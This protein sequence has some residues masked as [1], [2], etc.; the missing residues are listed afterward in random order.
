MIGDLISAGAIL[1]G[2]HL[3]RQSQEGINQ[4]VLVDKERDRA[5]QR[6]FAQSG[7]QWKVEDAK[8]AGIHPIFALGGSNATYTPSAISLGADTSTGSAVAKVG[9][10]VGRA[11][12]ATRTEPDRIDAYT[13]AVQKLTLEKGA[14]ENQLLGSQIRKLN[15]AGTPPPMSGAVDPYL[16][17]G[18]T[19][20]GV[21]AESFI[22]DDPLKRV[23]GATGQPQ[24]EP[25]AVTDV[26]YARTKDGY[27]P[28]P[29]KDVK[30][31]IEDNIIQ[32]IM[33]AVRNNVLPSFGINSSPPP[34]PPRS[35]HQWNFDPLQ[36][37]Y[38]ERRPFKRNPVLFKE[39]R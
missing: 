3:S 26:G 9:Q 19:Q 30:E 36:Q 2:G 1:L 39:R 6:E 14:L 25:G 18:Q 4:Q 7:I 15:Q 20:S 31:R 10:D 21:K 33:W 29:S 16:I 28:V 17:S 27:A 13:Q 35:G 12:N 32:E 5:L 38:Y 11:I 24:S 8:K 37:Q 22:K 34:F 23:P